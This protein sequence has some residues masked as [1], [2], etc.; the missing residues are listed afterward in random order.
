MNESHWQPPTEDGPGP[1]PSPWSPEGAGAWTGPTQVPAGVP[2]VP[3]PPISTGVPPA[4]APDAPVPP[5]DHADHV[6]PVEPPRKR[7]KLVVAGVLA[8]VVALGLAG[9]FAVQRFSEE[10]AGG[11]ASADELGLD[12]LAAIESEDVLGMIDT[13]LPGERDSLGEPFVDMVGEL[14]RLEILS[15][16]TDL[17]GL[18]G[19][20]VELT[21]EAV[22]VTGTNVPDIVNV[23]VEAD[24]AITL[25]GA[26]LPIGSFIEDQLPE[27]ALT[28]LRGTKITETDELSLELTAV[29]DGDRWYFSVFHTAAE[30]ARQESGGEPI[31]AEGVVPE[32]GDSPEAAVNGILDR[33]EA[34]DVRGIIATLDP[35]EAAAL[36]R[37]ALLFLDEA[38]AAV[39]EAPIDWQID[40]REFRV[41]GDGD[42][43]TVFFDAIGVSGE[44]EGTPFSASFGD[45]CIRAEFEGESI[46]ECGDMAGGRLE[47]LFEDAPAVEAFTASLEE[48]FADIEPV[49]LELRLRDGA[50]YVSPLATFT[51]ALLSAMRALD[52]SELDVLVT[53]GEA[54]MAEFAELFFGGFGMMDEEFG[55]GEDYELGDDDGVDEDY[56]DDGVD[57]D[58]AVPDD[59]AATAWDECYEQAAAADAAACFERH[60]AT[61]EIDPLSVPTA[62]LHPEC[63]LAEMTWEGGIYSATDEEFA[64][65]LEVAVPCFGALVERGELE[66]W[67][68]P[69][70]VIHA[71]CFE[72][73]NWYTEFED[74]AYNERVSACIDGG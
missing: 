36:Q 35:A 24:A 68:V 54:A 12:L 4:P 58:V 26:T 67:M 6:S 50:W 47:S 18:L 44:V 3:P 20:D 8:A 72:G 70:E 63:G 40:I 22:R 19:L 52:R 64:A 15:A 13:M 59:E 2:T 1:E 49:G 27:E 21:D 60:V 30:L 45:G 41:E 42:V 28:E 16:E 74:D 73:R 14:Q 56:G 11:A 7:S 46:E 9:L 53:E 17:S 5:A 39:A 69:F 23:S 29:Q 48:A 32:G 37:Y 10:D 65:A 33:M 43:R 55:I 31:P 25:D 71:D 61:G 62:L 66:E 38:E 51:E 34:L 57:E